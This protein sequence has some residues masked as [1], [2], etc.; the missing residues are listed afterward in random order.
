MT[1]T[2]ET[3]SRRIAVFVVIGFERLDDAGFTA[4]IAETMPS[5]AA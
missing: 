3:S 4:L 1:I 2:D 5:S